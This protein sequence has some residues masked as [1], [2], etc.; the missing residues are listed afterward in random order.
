MKTNPLIVLA[1]VVGGGGLAA[2]HSNTRAAS[3]ASCNVQGVWQA[4]RVTVNGQPYT[5]AMEVKIVTK[6]HFMWVQQEN[7]R[8]TLPLRTFQDTARVF[9]DAGGYGTY[10]LSG[11]NYIERIEAFPDPTFIGKEWPATCKTTRTQW[12]HSYIS[13]ERTDAN[14]RTRRD[15]VVEVLRRVE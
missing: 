15:T 2:T 1:L 5:A 14:G 7:R 3:A 11:N 12:T 8:D 13:P 6:N 10:R 9:N 4:E